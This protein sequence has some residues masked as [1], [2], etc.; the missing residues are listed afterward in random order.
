MFVDNS[1][2][3]KKNQ[4]ENLYVDIKA[5]KKIIEIGGVLYALNE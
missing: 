3:N 2:E 5:Q 4:F 1:K